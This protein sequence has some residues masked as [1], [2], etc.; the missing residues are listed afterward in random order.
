MLCN[1]LLI[2]NN[3]ASYTLK[4][5]N[6]ID[7]ILS[8]LTKNKQPNKQQPKKKNPQKNTRKFLGMMDMFNTL[9]WC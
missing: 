9:L 3:T 2:L 8:T 4:K 1:I 5:I 6:R 7:L